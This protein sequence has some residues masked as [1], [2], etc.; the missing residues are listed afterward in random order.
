MKRFLI[1]YNFRRLD[2]W[3]SVF[4]WFGSKNES[5]SSRTSRTRQAESS[6]TQRGAA[7]A[8][9]FTS[10]NHC[11]GCLF[12]NESSSKSLLFYKA[13]NGVVPRYISNLFYYSRSFRSSRRG[14]LRGS[15]VT[16]K[17][18]H[19]LL[20]CSSPVAQASWGLLSQFKL[21]VHNIPSLILT[22][23]IKPLF[24]SCYSDQMYLSFYVTSCVWKMVVNLPWLTLDITVY[25]SPKQVGDVAVSWVNLVFWGLKFAAAA[26]LPPEP[27]SPIISV[28]WKS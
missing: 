14:S 4:V 22:I 12:V 11:T 8:S 28:F 6:P 27:V 20:L 1:K 9:L 26:H 2:Y 21:P 25:L 5:H 19:L 13:L 7:C 18:K 10:V 15:K 16:N 3:N 17:M 24:F 23:L